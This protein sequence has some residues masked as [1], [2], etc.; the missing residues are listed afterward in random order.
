MKMRYI[1]FICL[2]FIPF[3]IMGEN[4]DYDDISR[5]Q[6]LASNI[7]F[8][9]DYVE[10]N[11]SVSFNIVITNMPSELYIKDASGNIIS[12]NTV[13]NTETV[14][15]G[16]QS[17]NHKFDIYSYDAACEDMVISSS[18][19]NLPYYNPYYKD[20]V[21]NS[22]TDYEYCQKW[23]EVKLS[24]DDFVKEVNN[25][26]KKNNISD[27]SVE[28]AFKDDYTNDW[29]NKIITIFL[30]NYIWIL[31]SLIVVCGTLMI[32]L[33]RKDRFNLK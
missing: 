14:L 4:C 16:Y 26:K 11:N 24:R 32:I 15:T 9:Y 27:I 33:I 12:Y 22:I 23:V 29:L 30:N 5:Y 18:Y 10:N 1:I 2:L 31:V 3:K 6:K 21:C 7:K 28:D 8:N 13:F 19:V 20:P 25:Y 17:G